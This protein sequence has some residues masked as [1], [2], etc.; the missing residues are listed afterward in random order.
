MI[1]QMPYGSMSNRLRYDSNMPSCILDPQQPTCIAMTLS[2]GFRLTAHTRGMMKVTPIILHQLCGAHLSKGWPLQ[3]HETACSGSGT[4]RVGSSFSTS[5]FLR[6]LSPQMV[7]V[8]NL[9]QIRPS[10]IEHKDV[11]GHSFARPLPRDLELDSAYPSSKS[12]VST[13]VLSRTIPW[14]LLSDPVGPAFDTSLGC[15]ALSS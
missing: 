1:M 2:H 12:H 11:G 4:R 7:N 3:R 5:Y 15:N 14:G 9:V 13:S 8:R 6:H 10:S